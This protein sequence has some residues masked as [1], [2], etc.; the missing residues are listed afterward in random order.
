MRHL[1]LNSAHLGKFIIISL[2]LGLSFGCGEGEKDNTANSKFAT[3][4]QPAGTPI[5]QPGVIPPSVL[6]LDPDAPSSLGQR[7]KPKV[8]WD[9]KSQ[10]FTLG[11]D[12]TLHGIPMEEINNVIRTRK[13]PSGPAPYIPPPTS[14]YGSTFAEF[15]EYLIRM[16]VVDDVVIV[17]GSGTRAAVNRESGRVIMEFGEEAFLLVNK[18]VHEI[19]HAVSL[20]NG[21]H[22]D[23]NP[24][25]EVRNMRA[26]LGKENLKRLYPLDQLAGEQAYFAQNNEKLRKAEEFF[27]EIGLQQGLKDHSIPGETHVQKLIPKSRPSLLSSPG[28]VVGIVAGTVF[29]A[30]DFKSELKRNSRPNTQTVTGPV[31]DAAI[32]TLLKLNPIVAVT[33]SNFVDIEDP[34]YKA[35]MEAYRLGKKEFYY[36]RPDDTV[37]H[38]Y[39]TI[40]GNPKIESMNE[41]GHYYVQG[42]GHMVDDIG[43]TVIDT[44]V[45]APS[46]FVSG[47]NYLLGTQPMVFETVFDEVPDQRGF[48]DYHQPLEPVRSPR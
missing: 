4:S 42:A 30:A 27:A 7:A 21:T 44:V 20:L 48:Q 6:F 18:R 38:T 46:D 14:L 36:F 13:I 40:T 39:S 11:K 2:L 25:E 45:S 43:D 5:D 37:G 31:G 1:Q 35:R 12:S 8:P 22:M 3:Q 9:G 41:L 33:A 10:P 47:M 19:G 26:I 24:A 16:G 15:R 28:R 34:F 29:V 23:I 32:M 17:P